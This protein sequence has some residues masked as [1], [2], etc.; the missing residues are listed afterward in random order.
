MSLLEE[1]YTVVGWHNERYFMTAKQ[2]CERVLTDSKSDYNWIASATELVRVCTQPSFPQKYAQ[3]IEIAIL[4]CFA[5]LETKKE[6]GGHREDTD[7]EAVCFCY[8]ALFGVSEEADKARQNYLRAIIQGITRY[9]FG[10][11]EFRHYGPTYHQICDEWKNSMFE[12]YSSEV[13]FNYDQLCQALHEDFDKTMKKAEEE[14]AF[15]EDDKKNRENTE[16]M[17]RRIMEGFH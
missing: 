9:H 3:T 14:G 4:N 11:F 5:S 7:D 6:F 8:R 13:H 17:A 15:E 1:K 12:K 2:L 10:L 16:K